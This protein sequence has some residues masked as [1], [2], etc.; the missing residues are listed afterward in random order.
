M[1]WDALHFTLKLSQTLSQLPEASACRGGSNG[2]AWGC[3]Q[4]VHGSVLHCLH[5]KLLLLALLAQD[6]DHMGRMGLHGL[7]GIARGASWH[8][9]AH[10]VLCA[11]GCTLVPFLRWNYKIAEGI[12]C[13]LLTVGEGADILGI[14]GRLKQRNDCGLQ[15]TVG[16]LV[17]I[18][19]MYFS[20]L[21]L[22]ALPPIQPRLPDS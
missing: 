11:H 2:A 17:G 15:S 20:V 19:C 13:C 8:W 14:T 6:R 4:H 12:Y 18:G 22:I 10:C 21:T 5:L 7:D 1:D 9:A 3:G 16:T